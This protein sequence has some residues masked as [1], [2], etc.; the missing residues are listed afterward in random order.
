MKKI[1]KNISRVL[2][3][4]LLIVSIFGAFNV[5]AEEVIFKITKIEVKEKSDKVKVNDVSLSGG[6]LINDIVFTDVNDYVK[7]D[8]TIQNS[9]EDKYKI[10]SITDDNDSPYLEYTYDDLSN[11]YINAG[12]EKT[13]NLTITYKQETSNITITDKAVSL[14]LIYE[15]DDGTTGTETIT[16][17]DN[18]ATTG[19]VKGVETTNPKTG[20]NVTTYIILG[21]ISLVGLAI[22]TVSKKHLSNVLSVIALASAVAIPL[23][24]KA[25]SNKFLI[26]FT[27]N[28]ASLSQTYWDTGVNIYY[29][30]NSLADGRSNVIV[31]TEAT[32]EQYEEVK[33][34]LTD[35]NKISI[36][37]QSDFDTYMWFDNNTKTIYWYSNA[38]VQYLNKNS[39]DL[40]SKLSNLT[41]VNISSLNTSKVED[42]GLMFG[43]TTSL[44]QLDLSSFDTSNVTN[45]WA[46]FRDSGVETIDLSSFDT[47]KV[48]RMDEM[49]YR[50][51]IKT[52]DVSSFDTSNVENFDCMFS[53]T[54]L[55][56]LDVSNFDGSKAVYNNFT[57]EENSEL[58]TI[59]LGN[60]KM[61]GYK[62]MIFSRNPKLKTIYS[63]VDWNVD[64]YSMLFENTPLL[65]GGE[66]TKYSDI[67]LNEVLK[68]E[69]G[70]KMMDEYG[71]PIYKYT[72]ENGNRYDDADQI[73]SRIDEGTSKPGLFTLQED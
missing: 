1:I 54:K 30:I 10:L 26:S 72:D 70:N 73:L 9:S 19:E 29:K 39:R 38:S 25:D 51:Q 40:C 28:K 17:D 67:D 24:V 21:I 66:G 62:F 6:S 57:F 56:T 31:F 14:I 53:K 5:L 47:S 35:D 12:E 41:T 71:N 16:N 50:S 11:V 60:F 48:T 3:S 68:D 27:T 36:D 61:A 49:F 64:S 42:M 18:N 20:D 8:I 37:D 34:N 33:D 4:L 43:G 13:F 45:M 59:Y 2:F 58:E 23:G 52:I 15:K 69:H 44:K 32:E 55:T 7:Y 22:T 65:E 46:M 63:K